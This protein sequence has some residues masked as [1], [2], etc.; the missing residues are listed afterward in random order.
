MANAKPAGIP[1]TKSP[2]RPIPFIPSTAAAAPSAIYDPYV[3]PIN[4]P[5]GDEAI[6]ANIS[7]ILGKRTEG[8]STSASKKSK[9]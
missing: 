7:S 1:V 3:T 2:F 6:F 9:K 8:H 5:A 4:L